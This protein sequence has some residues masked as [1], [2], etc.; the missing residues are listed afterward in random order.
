MTTHSTGDKFP[1]WLHQTGQWTKKV[2]GKM[3]YFGTDRDNALAEYVRVRDDLE[4]GRVPRPK[5]DG[6]T[7]AALC[8]EFLTAKRERVESGELSGRMWSEYH[9]AC[10]G[11]I[12]G[13]G[14]TRAVDDLRAG[15]FGKLRSKA[16]KRLGPFSIAK[17]VQMVRTVFI[18]AYDSE[19][20]D[21]PIRYGDQFDK[22]AGLHSPVR[23]LE[24]RRQADRRYHGVEV[25]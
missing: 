5:T 19:L 6:V 8:N 20:I 15:D 13:F 7:V 2:R 12:D 14:R 9:R 18:F 24:T 22:P 3:F 10:E 16:V 21:K 11:I 4:A 1:L 23:T 25:D 17:F